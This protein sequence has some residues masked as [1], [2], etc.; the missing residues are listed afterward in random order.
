MNDIMYCVI[1][2]SFSFVLIS[3]GIW[4][5]RETFKKDD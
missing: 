4:L 5:L 1:T 2:A 3:F